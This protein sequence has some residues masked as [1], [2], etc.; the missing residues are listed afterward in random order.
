MLTD[1]RNISHTRGKCRYHM[2][3]TKYKNQAEESKKRIDA[4]YR[5]IEQNNACNID[6]RSVA[7]RDVRWIKL[8]I[9]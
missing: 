8:P 1:S 9:T 7:V 4:E 3:L 2:V 5:F 6:V